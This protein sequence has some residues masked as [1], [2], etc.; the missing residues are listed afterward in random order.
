MRHYRFLRRAQRIKTM[1]H[2]QRASEEQ[3]FFGKK[4]HTWQKIYIRRISKSEEAVFQAVNRKFI[5]VL[6]REDFWR[7]IYFSVL[8][9]TCRPDF[10][11]FNYVVFEGRVGFWRNYDCAR[12]SAYD[13]PKKACFVKYSGLFYKGKRVNESIG[14]MCLRV[15]AICDIS[16]LWEKSIKRSALYKALGKRGEAV[17]CSYLEGIELLNWIGRGCR[18]AGKVITK[19]NA[20]YLIRSCDG[21]MNNIKRELE[22]LLAYCGEKITKSDIDKIVTKMPQSRVFEMSMPWWERMRQVCLTPLLSLR[23][24]ESAF[25]VSC[26]LYT[27]FERIFIRK[28]CWNTPQRPNSMRRKSKFLPILYATI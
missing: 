17:E 6:R 15:W 24:S 2:L 11:E 5:S 1:I 3:T 8:R 10:E 27:N 23:R 25:M 21:G 9:K 13:G 18:E 16:F 12:N 4:A 26:M 7:A 14:A 22:K 28:F 19:E 20:E